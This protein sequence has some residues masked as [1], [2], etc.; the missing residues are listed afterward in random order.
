M[1]ENGSDSHFR[2]RCSEQCNTGYVKVLDQNQMILQCC[3]S[4]QKCPPNK[5]VRNDWCIPCD[6]KERGAESKCV[7]LPENYLD[8]GTNTGYPFQVVI[9]VLSFSGLFLTMF[10]VILFV[11]FNGNRIVRA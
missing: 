6:E 4:C 3:W 2:A 7:P 1:R 10:V 9:L 5:I 8:L 11:K